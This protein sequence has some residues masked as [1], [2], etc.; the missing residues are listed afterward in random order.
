MV[1][2]SATLDLDFAVE[3]SLFRPSL[4]VDDEVGGLI[5]PIGYIPAISLHR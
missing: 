3:P 1:S 4:A 5:R 2:R